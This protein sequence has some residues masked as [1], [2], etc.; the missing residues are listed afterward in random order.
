MSGP[1]HDYDG[2]N[3][4]PE[5]YAAITEFAEHRP[6]WESILAVHVRDRRGLCEECCGQLGEPVSHPCLLR[7]V[8]Y[9]AKM[10]WEDNQRPPGAQQLSW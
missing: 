2:P 8:A 1:I 6:E 3:G 9:L 10:K 7:Q 5:F 4:G